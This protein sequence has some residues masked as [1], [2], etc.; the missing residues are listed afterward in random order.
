VVRHGQHGSLEV[1]ETYGSGGVVE[2]AGGERVRGR[3]GLGEVGTVRGEAPGGAVELRR[4]IAR[5]I[6]RA[7][8]D[9]L[10]TATYALTYGLAVG[11]RI[12]NQADHRAVG[13]AVLDAA[14]DAA[15]RWIFPELLGDGLE[16]WAGTTDTYVMGSNHPT[17]AVDVTKSLATGVASLRAHRAYLEGLGRNFDPEA[18]LRS[19]TAQAGPALGVRHA[20]A[21]GRIQLQGV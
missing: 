16:P 6:R 14:R 10:L 2:R 18:F 3:D 13:T 11:Q 12:L 20:V 8:P 19:F 4:D 7:R 5:H 1:V 15:N 21:F 9:I 17:H